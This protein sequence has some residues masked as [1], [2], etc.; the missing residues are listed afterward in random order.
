MPSKNNFKA[1]KHNKLMW[2]ASDINFKVLHT[3]CPIAHGATA[4]IKILL[5]SLPKLG[6]KLKENTKNT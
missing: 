4:A 2:L 3:G 6:H 5:C 1:Q